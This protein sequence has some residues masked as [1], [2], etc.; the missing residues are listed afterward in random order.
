MSWWKRFDIWLENFLMDFIPDPET[1]PR[2]L[3]MNLPIEPIQPPIVIAP[4]IK[5]SNAEKIYQAAFNAI[6]KDASPGDKAPDDRA[7]AE[8]VS[9]IIRK[10]FPDFPIL[11]STIDLDKKL[12]SDL[13]RFKLVPAPTAGCITV[14]P[15]K[16]SK[17]GHCWIR[18]KRGYAMSNTSATGRWEANYTDFG[19]IEAARKRGL[20]LFHYLPI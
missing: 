3:P 7:C 20:E 18:G 13:M 19:V 4:A 2:T 1:D 9:N 14:M 17:I 6:G 16:G 10:V 11:L 15:T 8:S 5:V 12:W